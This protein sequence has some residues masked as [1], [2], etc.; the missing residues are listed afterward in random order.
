M[1]T[2]VT[3]DQ[4]PVYETFIISLSSS[5]ED[6][7]KQLKNFFSPPTQTEKETTYLSIGSRNLHFPKTYIFVAEEE[8]PPKDIFKRT[9][10]QKPFDAISIK[11]LSFL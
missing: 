9:S 2:H 7:E 3:V 1:M 11:R 8:P 6:K 10:I 5:Y 4:V